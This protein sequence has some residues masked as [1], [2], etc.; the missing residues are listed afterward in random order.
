[1]FKLVLADPEMLKNSIPIIAEIIDEGVFHI[2]HN[3]VSL[4]TPDR[5]MVS[6]VDFKL[7]STAFE[8][9]KIEKDVALG[10]N[11]ANLSAVLRRAK[12]QDK[13]I[14]ES[15][16]DRLR[17]TLLGGGKRVFEI[18]IIETKTEKPPVDQLAFGGRIE[19]D[20]GVIEEG[21]ADADVIGDSIIFEAN[22]TGFRMHAKGDVSSAELHMQKGDSGL[23]EVKVHKAIRSQY[24]LDYLKKMIKAGKLAKRLVLEFGTD[25][26]IR[27]S[28]KTVDK[29]NLSFILA[30]RVTED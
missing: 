18:P 13:V 25:Y 23:H 26:P 21:I 30:P 10:L 9:F 3:G 15:E 7:L 29:M 6:V 28:F 8:E 2:T 24:P 1:M 14:L 4:L 20:T 5:A 19:I 27:L 12:A 17:I 16:G 22:E 11:L